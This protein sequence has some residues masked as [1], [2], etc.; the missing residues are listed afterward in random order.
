MT[1]VHI[2]DDEDEIRNLLDDA[3]TYEGFETRTF[4][5]GSTF[6][7]ASRK[8]RPDVVLLDLMMPE[9]DGWGV[10]TQLAERDDPPPVLAVTAMMDPGSRLPE[11]TTEA[12][13]AVIQKPFRLE[14][15][16]DAVIE[17][18]GPPS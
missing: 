14:E 7:E 15:L 2:V 4:A 3:L 17:H 12:F 8:Q 6:L 1:L 16:K 9:M 18:A 11:R 13:E 10:V 5:D